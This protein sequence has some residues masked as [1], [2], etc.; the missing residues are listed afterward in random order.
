MGEVMARKHPQWRNRTSGR[1][2]DGMKP[3][4]LLVIHN[5]HSIARI[6]SEIFACDTQTGNADHYYSTLWR[7]SK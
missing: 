1:E 3:G 2:S 5:N 7:V 6:V 4:F